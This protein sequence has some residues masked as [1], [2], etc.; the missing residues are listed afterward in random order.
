MSPLV[1]FLDMFSTRERAACRRQTL[2]VIIFDV[3]QAEINQADA[4]DALQEDVLHLEIAM[5]NPLLTLRIWEDSNDLNIEKAEGRRVPC[6]A[7]SVPS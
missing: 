4:M 7:S 1:F 5:D 6:S 2:A 3:T